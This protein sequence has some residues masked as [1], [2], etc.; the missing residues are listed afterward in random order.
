MLLNLHHSIFR[1]LYRPIQRLLDQQKLTFYIL[2]II[3]C[4][5]TFTTKFMNVSSNFV[6]IWFVD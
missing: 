5:Y 4:G 3:Y 1:K 6:R 2:R